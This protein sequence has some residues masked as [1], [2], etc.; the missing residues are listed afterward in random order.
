MAVTQ[1]ADGGGP[2]HR[3]LI[4]LLRGALDRGWTLRMAR[5]YG[6]LVAVCFAATT[7]IAARGYGADGTVIALAARAAATIAWVT[8][9]A[10]LAL[11][12]P[13]KDATFRQGALALASARGF[14]AGATDRAEMAA[15]V[16]LLLAIAVPPVAAL[17]VFIWLVEAQAKVGREAWALV[18]S[19]VFVAI[20]AILL[21]AVSSACRQWG[22]GRGRSL[23]FLVVLLPWPVALL[24]LPVKTADLA[25]I[26]GLLGLFW[27]TLTRVPG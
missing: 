25:S 9:F 22:K 10:A 13:P 21:G 18:G 5:I 24:V 19:C 7:W 27:D 1:A 8:G 17:G 26:P 15:T 23:F 11:S 14:A 2:S 12:A 20:T 3:A 4:R 6:W 16:R